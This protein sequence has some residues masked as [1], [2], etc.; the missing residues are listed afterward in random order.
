MFI[1]EITHHFYVP[2]PASLYELGLPL[3]QRAVAV[4]GVPDLKRIKKY[5]YLKKSSADKFKIGES[6]SAARASFNS[7]CGL[8]DK[9]PTTVCFS[10]WRMIC[11]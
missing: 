2:L 8:I 9:V 7:A 4:K 11:L 3:M 1:F 5:I 10:L 6:R